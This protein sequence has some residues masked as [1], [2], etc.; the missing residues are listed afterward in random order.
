DDVVRLVWQRASAKSWSVVTDHGAARL[1]REARLELLPLSGVGP[2]SRLQDDGWPIR[3][4][5]CDH[6]GEGIAGRRHELRSISNF[7]R[8]R[9]TRSHNKHDQKRSPRAHHALASF[10]RFIF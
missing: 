8:G 2:S 4:A 3:V 6:E 5:F 7:S 10:G 9:L 1:F